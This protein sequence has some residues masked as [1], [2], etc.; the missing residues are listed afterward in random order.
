MQSDVIAN[1]TSQVTSNVACD[2]PIWPESELN[3]TNKYC[4]TNS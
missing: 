1:A 3:R 4:D 2:I